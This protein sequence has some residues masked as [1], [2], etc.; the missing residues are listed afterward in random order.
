MEDHGV[1]VNEQCPCTQSKCQIRGKCVP[2]VQTHLDRKH[3]IPECFQ[4]LLRASIKH[5]AAMVELS[6]DEA[7]PSWSSLVARDGDGP[8]RHSTARRE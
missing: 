3:H 8:A 2:C 6:S 5:L 4:D 1:S 7:R